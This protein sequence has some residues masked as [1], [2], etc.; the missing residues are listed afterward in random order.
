MGNLAL[1]PRAGFLFVDFAQGYLLQ[2]SARSHV[3]W[4]NAETSAAIGAA[5]ML[6]PEI[7]GGHWLRDALD[8]R[9]A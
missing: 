7:N 6:V 4:H 3:I 1:D 8:L 9:W 2:L 5:L